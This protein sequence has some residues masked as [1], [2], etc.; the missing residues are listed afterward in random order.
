MEEALL[1]IQAY[2]TWIYVILGLALVVY[3]RSALRGWREL[4]LAEFGL[5]RERARRGATRAGAMVAWIAVVAALTFV[6]ATFLSPAVPATM[7]PTALPTV[8]LLATPFTPVPGESG[9]AVTS[10]PQAV[11]D[12]TGCENELATLTSPA[13]G[14]E[15][16]GTV[17]IEGTANIANFAFYKYEY[18]ALAGGSPAPG[19]VWRAISADTTP[20]VEGELGVWDTTLVIPGDYAFRLVVT[21]TAGNAPLPCAVRVRVLPG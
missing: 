19:A 9:P 15:L 18:V 4:R 6:T 17:P 8:S 7:R 1:L 14:A 10:L 13:E 16:R 12:P 2:Q 21:D 3:G 5:E 11:I 20:V